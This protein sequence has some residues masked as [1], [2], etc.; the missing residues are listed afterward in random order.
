ME[1]IVARPIVVLPIPEHT[2]TLVTL[3]ST[4]L[5]PLGTGGQNHIKVTKH[6]SSLTERAR[7]HFK[8]SI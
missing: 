1:S 7:E 3:Y 2:L 8:Q 5:R 4:T 6:Y